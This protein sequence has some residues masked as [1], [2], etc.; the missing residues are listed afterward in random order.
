[1]TYLR[2]QHCSLIRILRLQ[3]QQL[4]SPD[5][6]RD[7]GIE[8]DS[9]CRCKHDTHGIDGLGGFCLFGELER[10]DTP[11]LEGRFDGSE[12]LVGAKGYSRGLMQ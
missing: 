1:M 9:L 7:F 10:E 3:K 12:R 2:G 6:F 8:N 5:R 4:Y 11:D